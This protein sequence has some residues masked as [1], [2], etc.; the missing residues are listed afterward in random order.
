SPRDARWLTP[1][2]STCS[3]IV[4]LSNWSKKMSFFSHNAS[5][6]PRST[7][8]LKFWTVLPVLPRREMMGRR[9]H[10]HTRL[11][12]S[13]SSPDLRTNG[14]QEPGR[15]DRPARTLAMVDSLGENEKIASYRNSSTTGHRRTLT[16]DDTLCVVWFFRIA[17]LPLSFCTIMKLS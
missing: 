13:S 15:A 8:N 10:Q 11:V 3:Q 17:L 16:S 6:V 5:T 12:S 1:F 4:N 14:W 2:N 9:Y 7:V